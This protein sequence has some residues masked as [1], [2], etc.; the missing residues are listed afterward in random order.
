MS[1]RIFLG[2]GAAGRAG[3]APDSGPGAV[4]G[5]NDFTIAGNLVAAGFSLATDRTGSLVFCC[6]C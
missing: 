1:V 3:I 2:E 5:L 4:A 6:T